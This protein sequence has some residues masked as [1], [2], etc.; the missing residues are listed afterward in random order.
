MTYRQEKNQSEAEPQRTEMME[1]SNKELTAA[2]TNIRTVLKVMKEN[3]NTIRRAMED[4][5]HPKQKLTNPSGTC[6][7]TNK[8]YS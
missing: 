1:S 6:R 5:K 3:M 8:L 2:V 7:Y 4:V